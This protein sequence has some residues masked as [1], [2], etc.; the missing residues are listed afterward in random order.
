LYAEEKMALADDEKELK[1][2]QAKLANLNREI[3]A[4]KRITPGLPLPPKVA[5]KFDAEKK[6]YQ[7]VIGLLQQRVDAQKKKK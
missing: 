3:E 4:A 5:A 6:E 7:R 1:M 2:F